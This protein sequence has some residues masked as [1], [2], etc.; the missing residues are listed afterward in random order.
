WGRRAACVALLLALS[1]GALL[2]Y[3]A[4]RKQHLEKQTAEFA[5]NGDIQSGVLVARRLLELDPD[6]LAA[7]RSMAEMAEQSGKA[8]AVTWRQKIAHREPTPANQLALAR[9]ALKFGQRDLAEGVLKTVP[10][11]ARQT[12]DYQQV[13]GAEALARKDPAAA[14]AHFSSALQLAPEN[15]QLAFN[16][17]ALRLASSDANA[18]QDARQRLVSLTDQPVVRLEALRALAADALLHGDRATATNWTTQL[19]AEAGATFGDALL[20]FQAVEG[21]DAAAP[22]MAEL[23]AKAAA[24]G[25]TAAELI[26]WMNRHGMAAVAALWSSSL[27]QQIATTP[28]VPLAIAESYS[29]LRDW[30]ALRAFVQGK[31]WGQHESLRLAVEAHAL[32]RLSPSDRESMQTQTTWRAALKAAHPHPEQLIAIAQLAEGWG[33]VPEAVEAWWEVADGK[34]TAKLGLTALQRLYKSKQDT[35]GLLRVA[36]RA[37][38]LNPND[39]VAA[40]NAASLGLLLTGDTTARR[41]ALKL[42]QEHP[43]NRAFAATY[44]FALH[45]EGKRAEALRVLETLKE[46][47]LRHPAIAAYYVMMLVESGNLERARSFLVEARRA[48]L[49]PEE[50]QLLDA[51]ARKLMTDDASRGVAKK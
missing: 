4:W 40:N 35:R 24:S 9:A 42:H 19:R 36:K 16:V 21:T 30:N 8:E 39:L 38:E 32:H 45:T 10:E 5:R 43:K 48:A 7:A 18:V 44:A 17:A 1:Y 51:A 11:A 3:R 2:G 37:L 25:A 28:P 13:A 26:T 27:P 31:H 49:L 47:E 15:P 22:A 46:Q 20:Y 23:Q 12:V 33:Y 29:F 50:Q 34:E 6:N 14:E 41:L